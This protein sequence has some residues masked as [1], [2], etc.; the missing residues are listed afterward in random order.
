MTFD[1]SPPF[2]SRLPYVETPLIPSLYLSELI[3]AQ[4]YLKLELVQPSG[5]FKS[6]GLG[7]LVYQTVVNAEPGTILHFFSP[8]GGNAGCATAYAARQYGHKCTVCLPTSANPI[9]VERIKKTGAEVVVFGDFIADS[10]KHIRD[11][12]MPACTNTPV[13]CHPYNNQLVWDG[14]STIASEIV[15]QFLGPSTGDSSGEEGSD[16][17]PHDESNTF[18][19]SSAGRYSNDAR[20][21]DAVVCSVGGGGLYNGLIQGFEKLGWRHVP[22][23]AVE[24]EGCAALSLSIA[25]GGEQ[26]EINR[27]QTI[28]TS[29]STANV[30]RETIDYAMD[31]QRNCYSMVVSDKDAAIACIQFAK[32]H[33][34]LIE[35]ACGTALAPLYNGD[36]KRMLPHLDASSK[37]VVVICGGTA[38]SWKILE[39]YS[40]AF[41]I[42]L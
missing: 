10:D 37:V 26:I 15:A 19:V 13:Y 17:C 24:T 11:V 4:V 42:V 27:P 39:G 31:K 38:I 29:L 35:A 1:R 2:S 8:S 3:G 30:T 33:K 41:G 21:P 23:V 18:P 7:N 36:L 22:V 12:L 9:M 32:D 25:A 6:R 28:A 14:N 34:L 40:K 16:Y 5:S 20:I